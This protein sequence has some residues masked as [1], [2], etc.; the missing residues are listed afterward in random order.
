M[1]GQGLWAKYGLTKAPD[2]F[3]QYRMALLLKQKFM[4]LVGYVQVPYVA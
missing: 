1:G 3:S 2:G 4:A